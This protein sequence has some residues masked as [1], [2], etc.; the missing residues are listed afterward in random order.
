MQHL[1][2]QKIVIPGKKKVKLPVIQENGIVLRHPFS[3]ALVG[4][5]GSGKTNTLIWMVQ[6]LYK[7]FFP[8]IILISP[9]GASD[10][11]AGSLGATRTITENLVEE[12]KA[13][14]R[15]GRSKKPRLIIFEDC[16]SQ[17][18]LTSS[19]S[20]CQAY[21][22]LRHLNCSVVSCSHK[23]RAI[24]RIA[25]INSN[26]LIIFPMPNSDIKIFVEEYLPYGVE[27][28]AFLKMLHYAWSTSHDL[29]R[30]FLFV[31]NQ[32]QHRF[33]RG[34]AQVIKF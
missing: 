30:P 33:R 27:K 24:S 22:A 3:L 9:T 4:A 7:G 10:E 14:M 20:F 13:I 25:R 17:R 5:S 12:T 31:N 15:K 19:E 34:F 18:K 1:N 16:S 6:K 32:E 28:K 23:L 21:T 11:L 29:Q 8:E 26:G 2:P